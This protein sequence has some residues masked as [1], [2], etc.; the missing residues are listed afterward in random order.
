MVHPHNGVLSNKTEPARDT[1]SNLDESRG[2][3]ADEMKAASLKRLHAIWSVVWQSIKGKNQ[4]WRT[5]Q[6]LLGVRSGAMYDYKGRTVL[7][8]NGTVLH[9][10]VGSGYSNLYTC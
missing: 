3:R 7:E 8:S 4:W 9:P 6:W 10:D 2:H 5:G 1:H